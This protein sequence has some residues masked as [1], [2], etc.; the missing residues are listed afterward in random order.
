MYKKHSI[1]VII[2]AYNEEITIARVIETL[3]NFV[4]FVIV[5]DDGSTDQTA[6]KART[7]GAI[8]V[9][10]KMN[11]GLGVTFKTGIV[12][13]L[14]IGADIVVNIDADGQFDSSDVLKL[15]KP[16]VE[17]KAGFATAS[18]FKDPEFY[19]QMSKIKFYGNHL[20]SLLISI[21]VGKKFMDVSCGFRAYSRDTLLRLNLFGKFTYTQETFIDLVFKDITILEVPVRVRGTREFGK[22]K[23]ASNL[24]KY[25]YN[26][27]KIIFR[28]VRDYRALK[29]FGSLSIIA[30]AIGLIA[31][32]FFAAHYLIVGTFY[33]HK[34]AGFVSGFFILFS[35]FLFLL[36]F[37]M[38]MLSRIKVNQEAM[39]YYLKN[40][41]YP[42]KSNSRN[43]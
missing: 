30:F 35:I 28:V 22:S 14:E 24:I 17:G 39:L 13:A 42:Q 11:K 41:N 23:M 38:D 31:G 43:K 34:W 16:V 19:P 36:G 21:I 20:M 40:L 6:E 5:V 3:P 32:I 10:H 7:A 29:V 26:T 2:P 1:A 8:V 27:S 25:A 33:P 9:S 18:R 37:I 15:V 4:D 12:K